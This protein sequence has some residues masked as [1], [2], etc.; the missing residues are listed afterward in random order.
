MRRLALALALLAVPSAIAAQQTAAP[1]QA[2]LTIDTPIEAIVA[3]PA[4]KAVLE[5]KMPTLLTHPSYEQFKGMSL[6]ELQP[7]SQGA[8]TDEKLADVD[9]AL[10]AIGKK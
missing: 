3:V 5:A 2:P 4:G 9:A 7:Y 10:R 1:Q 8:I 6:K